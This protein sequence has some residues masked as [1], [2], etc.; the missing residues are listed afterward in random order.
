MQETWV[1]SLGWED[2]LE[3]EMA[4]H[5][6]VLA[7]KIP[8][9]EDSGGLQ[10]MGSQKRAGHDLVTKTTTGYLMV[11]ATNSETN[12]HQEMNNNGKNRKN[13]DVFISVTLCYRWIH[14]DLWFLYWL[15]II[16][17]LLRKLP[18]ASW[19][20]TVYIVTNSSCEHCD[21]TILYH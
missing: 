17:F 1:W 15:L 19:W 16:K 3:K 10:P 6:S 12:E 20:N 4:T 8:W 18:L 14:T 9:T 5:S 11:N 7:W 13:S 21:F 2:P